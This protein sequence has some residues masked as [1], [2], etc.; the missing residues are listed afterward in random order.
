M[1]NLINSCLK[2]LQNTEILLERLSDGLIYSNKTVAPYY[3]S[4]GSH[5]RHILDFYNCIVNEDDTGVNLTNRTRNLEVESCCSN[6]LSYF[7]EL[8][9][10][11]KSLEKDENRMLVVTDDLGSGIIKLNYTFGALMAQ[12]NSHT[13]HHYAII[14]YILDRLDVSLDDTRFGFNPTT[15]EVVRQY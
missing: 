15:P 7:N 6:A 4:I 5:V 11:L 13:I 9:D 14:N 8:I 1:S 2:T 10:K 12:A 3:S